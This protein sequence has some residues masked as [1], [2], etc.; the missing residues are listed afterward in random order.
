MRKRSTNDE[1]SVRK[2][3]GWEGHRDHTALRVQES[4]RV[5]AVSCRSR[6]VSLQDSLECPQILA[7]WSRK[8]TRKMSVSIQ[9][10][11][12]SFNGKKVRTIQVKDVGQ[13]LV[14]SD[15][16][17][18]IGY[19]R[20]A[21]VQAIQRLVPDKY[22]MRFRDVQDMLDGVLRFEYP[23]ADMVILKEPGV[24][25]FLLRCGKDEAAPF[26]EWTVETV[27]PSKVRKLNEAIQERDNTIME[28]D[29]RIRA[30]EFDNV[31]LQGEIRAKDQQI[32]TLIPRYVPKRGDYDN[33]LVLISKNRP[34]EAGKAGRHPYYMIRC[35]KQSRV[36]QISKVKNKYPNMVV[37]DTC[38]DPNAI[39]EWCSFKDLVLE[40]GDYHRNHFSL[41]A[42]QRVEFEE[43]F[44]MQA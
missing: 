15:I 17:K 44:E 30:I 4:A 41:N 35:Q 39:H 2:R 8:A 31:G 40:D 9:F 22:K 26:L 43:I 32:E 38:E 28:R 21:G 16:Y 42:A 34:E 5:S 3:Q 37:R 1:E 14:A 12:F 13:C 23:Q 11:S 36:I 6:Q 29:T 10:E 20:K 24:Y 25:T 7:T 33:I 19:S 27:L 18:A